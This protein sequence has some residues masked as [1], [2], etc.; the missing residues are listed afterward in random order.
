MKVIFTWS[1]IIVMNG[2]T[3]IARYPANCKVRQELNG[4]RKKNEVVYTYPEKGHRKPY[5]PRQ[6]PSGIFEITAIEWLTDSEKVKEFGH[7]KI[8]TTMKREVFVWSLDREGNYWQPTGEIQ[9]DTQY[10]IHHTHKY[11]H[12][13]G[14]IRGGDTDEQMASIARIIEPELRHGDPVYLE[15]L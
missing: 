11:K 6:A 15:V 10:H 7:V 4:K 2:N 3:E 14:C 8:K 1:E 13:L 5:Y 12:T 9:I